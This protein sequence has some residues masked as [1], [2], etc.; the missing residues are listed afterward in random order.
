MKPG[1][2]TIS[3]PFCFLV[4]IEGVKAVSLNSVPKPWLIGECVVAVGIC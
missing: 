1:K 2:F 3:T 4:N